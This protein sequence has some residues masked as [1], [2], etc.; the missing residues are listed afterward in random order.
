MC[1]LTSFSNESSGD[2]FLN[3]PT[4]SARRA[5]LFSA[6]LN[7]LFSSFATYYDCSLAYSLTSFFVIKFL[8]SSTNYCIRDFGVLS[9]SEADSII[10]LVFSSSFFTRAL[11]D[12]S[13]SSSLC[14]SSSFLTIRLRRAICLGSVLPVLEITAMAFCSS[15]FSYS[16][17]AIRID[18][19]YRTSSFSE[20]FL[21]VLIISARWLSILSISSLMMSLSTRGARSSYSATNY[22]L[23]FNSSKFIGE[24]RLSSR[25]FFLTSCWS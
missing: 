10:F 8:P 21:I 12:S 9:S 17:R 7:S 19:G 14:F 11:S 15:T 13:S 4:G 18:S 22:S 3:M 25:F 6:S 5:V 23:A 2:R 24:R 16:L 20:S 1:C